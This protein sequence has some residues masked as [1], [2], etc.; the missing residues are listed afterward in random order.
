[1]SPEQRFLQYQAGISQALFAFAA[2]RAALLALVF[3][4]LGALAFAALFTCLA[5]CEGGRSGDR[6]SSDGEEGQDGFHRMYLWVWVCY[7][8]A[9]DFAW[10]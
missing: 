4:A 10:F 6:N 3:A 1:M 2:V 7:G 9:K 5:T 8:S